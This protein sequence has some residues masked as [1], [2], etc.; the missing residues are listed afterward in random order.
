MINKSMEKAASIIGRS[1]YV[2]CLSGAG[3]SVPSG[4]P[5]FRGEGGLWDCYDPMEYAHIYTF[6]KDPEKIWLF[7]KELYNLVSI[8]EPN[9]AHIAI[10]TLEQKDKVKSVITQNIDNLHQKAGSKNVIEF[11]GNLYRLVCLRCKNLYQFDNQAIKG[12]LPKCGA[13]SSVLKPDIVFFG[14]A[15]PRPVHIKAKE[16]VA[17]T[18]V[19]LVVGTSCTVVPASSIPF[20]VKRNKGKVIEINVTPTIISDHVADITLL[21]PAEDIL[22]ELLDKVLMLH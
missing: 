4:I 5:A 8:A 17:Q 21:G 2:S 15:I 12:C 1:N 20:E 13:C 14:E 16:V 18:E 7:M 10:S 19:L 3:I 22:P 9:N 6:Q 11:H